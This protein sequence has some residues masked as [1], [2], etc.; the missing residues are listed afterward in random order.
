MRMTH[1]DSLL[2]AKQAILDRPDGGESS[3]VLP[4]IERGIDRVS[5]ELGVYTL[6]KT[7]TLIELPVLEAAAK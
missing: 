7:A 6:H 4:V 1:L 5:Q 3:S 2:V